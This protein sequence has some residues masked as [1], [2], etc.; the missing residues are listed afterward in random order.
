MTKFALRCLK[1]MRYAR[2]VADPWGGEGE[3]DARDLGVAR[4]VI[5]VAWPVRR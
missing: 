3:A 2:D 5:E 1:K 4:P